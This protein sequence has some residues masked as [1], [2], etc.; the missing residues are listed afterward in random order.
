[1]RKKYTLGSGKTRE[2]NREFLHQD[3][4]MSKVRK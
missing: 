1:M 3:I 4:L 2:E